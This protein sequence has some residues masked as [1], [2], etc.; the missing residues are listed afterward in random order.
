MSISQQSIFALRS[1]STGVYRI[2]RRNIIDEQLQDNIFISYISYIPYTSWLE[3]GINS[4]FVLIV[5]EE[6]MSISQ[7]SI[8]A[9]RSSSTGVYRIKR[10]NIIDEQLQDNI[11]ISYISYIPYTSW[12]ELGINSPFVLIVRIAL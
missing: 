7:Q 1:S 6:V 5:H 10:R 8:F 3:L 2:K 11:F 4:P 9:L 12:L